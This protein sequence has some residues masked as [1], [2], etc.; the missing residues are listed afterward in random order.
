MDINAKE[1]LRKMRAATEPACKIAMDYYGRVAGELKPDNS[2]V[3]K[4]DTSVELL[5]RNKLPRVVPDSV[6][7]GEEGGP[8]G[9]PVGEIRKKEFVWVIDPI[10]GTSAFLDTLP[11][12]CISVGLM[13]NGRPFA[14]ML[15]FPVTGDIYEAVAGY[16]SYYNGKRISI[17]PD[18]EYR[19]ECNLYV[20]QKAHIKYKISYKGRTQNLGSSAAHIAFVARGIAIGAV[21]R[22]CVWDFAAAAVIVTE[23]G[24]DI[25]YL[26]GRAINWPAMICS[27]KKFPKPVFAAE[28]SRWKELA[29][30]I[31]FLGDIGD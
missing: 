10:D 16:G 6:V 15:R 19:R 27:R 9:M 31:E 8:C 12:F 13:R 23:A 24:G 11:N 26:D 18:T 4:A 17:G 3:T 22:S 25:R 28:R 21:S 30:Q 5:L 29:S 2:Y 7:V 20:P 1:L 14:G